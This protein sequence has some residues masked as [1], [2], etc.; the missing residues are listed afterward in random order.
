MPASTKI[1]LSDVNHFFRSGVLIVADHTP[2]FRYR[3]FTDDVDKQAVQPR[4]ESVL[5]FGFAGMA[6]LL[7][8][9]GLYGVL[10]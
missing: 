10:S 1:L 6:L 8:A 5:V 9:V 2:V 4:F 7:S 3:T